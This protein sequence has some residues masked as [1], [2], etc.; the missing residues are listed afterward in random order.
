[1]HVA[2]EW[3]PAAEGLAGAGDPHRQRRLPGLCAHRPRLCRAPRGDGTL[4]RHPRGLPAQRPADCRRRATCSSSRTW[5]ATLERW[6]PGASTASI[7]ATTAKK[8]LAGVK[9]A[10][11]QMDGRGTGRLPVKEREPL[12]FQ[13]RRLEVTTAPPPSSGG[14]ALA[15]MLQILGPGTWRSCRRSAAHAPGDRGDAPRLPRPHLL[16]GRSRTS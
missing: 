4:P 3:S 13:Y 12:R 10:G 15:Q 14:I 8:L 2:R 9:A 5:R 16:P 6:P 1:V 7:A 11:G